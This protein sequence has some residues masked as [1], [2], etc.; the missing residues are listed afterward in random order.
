MVNVIFNYMYGNQLRIDDIIIAALTVISGI[1]I[2]LYT[3]GKR[4]LNIFKG[5]VP[6]MCLP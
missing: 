6:V 3:D 4:K 1:Q 2:F 5:T